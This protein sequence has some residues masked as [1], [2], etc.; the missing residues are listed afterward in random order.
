MLR[1]IAIPL[2]AVVLVIVALGL[3]RNRPRVLQ[4]P[5]EPSVTADA[6]PSP[7]VPPENLDDLLLKHAFTDPLANG[8]S[9]RQKPVG[10]LAELATELK[11]FARFPAEGFFDSF[12]MI[13]PGALVLDQ[14]GLARLT[15]RLAGTEGE[16]L[17]YVLGPDRAEG[18]A[19]LF[20]PGSGL[21]MATPTAAGQP[22]Y[23]GIIDDLA[24]RCRIHV[25]IKPN[26]DIRAIHDGTRK[27]S[28][29]FIY[30]YA[31]RHGSSYGVTYLTEA[32][33]LAARLKR[34]HKIFGIVGL[35][36][37]G[38]AALLLSLQAEPDFSVVAAGF[39]LIQYRVLWAGA[40]QIGLPGMYQRYSPD[41]MAA[42][43]A[44]QRTRYLFTYGRQDNGDYQMEA[45]TGESCA[46]LTSAAPERASC[47]IH[48]GGHEFPRGPTL[49]FIGR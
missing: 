23:G 29:D 45:W 35:S 48:D 16:A 2:I 25:L 49:D 31:V 43:I 14:A 24:R 44:R 36:Q 22:P 39:S 28:G 33:A 9:L 13:E 7:L 42:K 32:L 30:Q 37:G 40:D 41:R 15:F 10:S 11:Q 17:S 38:E 47:V 4:S 19:I 1:R 46:F 8:G 5:V 26:E 34:D 27:L 18:C 6:T 21:N 12:S 20:V 3:D